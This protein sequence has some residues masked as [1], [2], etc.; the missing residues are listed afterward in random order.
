MP[1]H[2]L[3]TET[4][5]A[6][7][8]AGDLFRRVFG[9]PIPGYPSHFVCLHRADDGALRTAGYVHFSAFESVHLVGGFVVDREMYRGAAR[10]HLEELRPSLTIGEH[11]MRE[12]IRA[13]PSSNAV[14]A[15]MGDRRS[16]EV[17]ERVGYERTHLPNLF[18]FWRRDL[19]GDAKRA[20]AERVMRVTPF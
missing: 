15:F 17:N 8:L 11:L 9:Q 7:F 1:A 14:F 10:A 4:H 5:D 16:I 13:L 6:A 3:V 12:A 18:A 19:P 20:L 2:F